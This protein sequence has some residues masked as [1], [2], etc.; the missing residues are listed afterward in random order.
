MQEYWREYRHWRTKCTGVWRRYE[1]IG[2]SAVTGGEV[3][4]AYRVLMR[5]QAV[6]IEVQ[7][8]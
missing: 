7:Q 8:T 2:E 5:I 4:C 1:G 3:K 6:E